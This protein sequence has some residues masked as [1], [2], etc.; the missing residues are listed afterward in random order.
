AGVCIL[1]LNHYSGQGFLKGVTGQ[2][3]TSAEFRRVV[4]EAADYEGSFVFDASMPA[5]TQRRVLVASRLRPLGRHAPTD[6]RR[7]LKATYADFLANGGRF[8]SIAAKDM[9]D[10]ARA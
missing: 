7:G 8:R 10:V 4:A 2:G 6:L 3:V 5:A 9:R 1:V